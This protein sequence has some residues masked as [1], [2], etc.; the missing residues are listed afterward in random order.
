MSL[1]GSA[2]GSPA[3]MP[4]ELSTDESEDF[5]RLPSPQLSEPDEHGAQCPDSQ[6]ANANLGS[7]IRSLLELGDS[8]AAELVAPL[9]SLTHE[10]ESEAVDDAW[11]SLEIIAAVEPD[12]SEVPAQAHDVEVTLPKSKKK[13]AKKATR[14]NEKVEG[15]PALSQGAYV[16]AQHMQMQAYMQ[17]AARS[18]Q[19]QLAHHW[20]AYMAYNRQYNM[21]A[22][23]MTY[24]QH[25]AHYQQSA[26]TG[27]RTC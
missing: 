22:A 2:T 9:Q 24:M 6:P 26:S 12:P 10:L 8:E 25:L 11:D 5:D 18:Q 19:M 20:Q 27:S 23:Q 7:L 14:I 1:P 15:D 17:Q 3:S 13:A 21:A 4:V 16:R